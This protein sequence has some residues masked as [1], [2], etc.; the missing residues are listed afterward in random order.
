MRRDELSLDFE[1]IPNQAILASAKKYLLSAELIERQ[2]EQLELGAILCSSFS[3]ELL[4]KSL[5]ANSSPKNIEPLIE[6]C[7]FYSGV[8]HNTAKGH[9]YIELYKRLSPEIQNSLTSSFV[10]MEVSEPLVSM[11]EAFDGV[12]VKWRYGF[13][14]NGK[15]LNITSLLKLNR[16]LYESVSSLKNDLHHQ[17]WTST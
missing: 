17:D 12:F 4:L 9:S 14:S 16:T 8:T 15:S 6:D 11:L 1:E 2:N 10:Y 13:E 3:I 7:W 5:L